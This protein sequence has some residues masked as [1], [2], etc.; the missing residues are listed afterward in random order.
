MQPSIK[1]HK[2]F[3]NFTKSISRRPIQLKITTSWPWKSFQK[4]NH[5]PVWFQKTNCTFH[6]EWL[7]LHTPGQD[8]A[9][10]VLT[11]TTAFA[12]A[13]QEKYCRQSSPGQC[14][15]WEQELH[16]PELVSSSWVTLAGALLFVSDKSFPSQLILCIQSHGHL[17]WILALPSDFAR[18]RTG[19]RDSEILIKKI[20]ML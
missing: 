3:L 7:P 10:W 17:K 16:S 1:A 13:L 4:W 14:E 5:F 15:D 9:R 6:V 2:Y 20:L 8:W 12:R 11:T 18:P 19:S